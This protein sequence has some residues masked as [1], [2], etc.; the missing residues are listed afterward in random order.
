MMQTWLGAIAD[1]YPVALY[2]DHYLFECTAF[3]GVQGTLLCSI[4]K[5]PKSPDFTESPS[6]LILL[7][8]SDWMWDYCCVL[9]RE[10]TELNVSLTSTLLSCFSDCHLSGLITGCH[11]MLLSALQEVVTT[12]EHEQACLLS[13]TKRS[14]LYWLV[15]E[16]C[17]AVQIKK[18]SAVCDGWN[19]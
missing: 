12:T 16:R 11:S 5:E 6:W 8:E 18:F 7:A 4:W 15:L 17:V 13:P 10:I 1:G 19:G 9:R 14:V 2:W 3:W